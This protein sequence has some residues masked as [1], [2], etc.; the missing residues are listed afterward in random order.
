MY[1]KFLHL[2]DI[3]W[4]TGGQLGEFLI[5]AI[6]R[7]ALTAAVCRTFGLAAKFV[8]LTVSGHVRVTPEAF[9]GYGANAF[10]GKS[11]REAACDAA[12][13]HR[14]ASE[15]VIKPFEFAIANQRIPT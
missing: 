11:L 15:I 4:Q 10:L 3:N 13:L 9:V 1:N 8:M 6:D 2:S 7:S 14:L 5:A 12:L